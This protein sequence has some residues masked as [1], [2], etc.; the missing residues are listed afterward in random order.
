MVLYK[1][2]NF[3]IKLGTKRKDI[4]VNKNN[5]EIVI[6]IIDFA[7]RQGFKTIA[8]FVSSKEIFDKVKE[9]GV[10]YAQGYYIGEPK[11]EILTIA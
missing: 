1:S 10:D 2:Y 11:V 4:L 7:K 6:T 8:E 3:T 5:Q 9:L